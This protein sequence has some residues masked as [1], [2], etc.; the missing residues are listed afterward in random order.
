[1]NTSAV[2]V[3]VIGAG[4]Y[5]LSTYAHLRR[6]GLRARIVGEPMHAWRAHMPSG[7]FLQSG[8]SGSNLDAGE[9]GFTLAD[10]CRGAGLDPPTGDGPIPVDL[11]LRYGAW[12]ARTLAPE[13]ERTEVLAVSRS[14]S[15]YR[16]G[17]ADGAEFDARSV[18]V[19]SG[20]TGH[21]YV[22]PELA[23]LASRDEP[24]QG[25]VSH[26]SQ[27]RDLSV[28]AGREVAVV[29]AGHSALESAALLAEAGA[30]P[31]VLAR[32][33]P[34]VFARAPAPADADGRRRRRPL[35]TPDSRLGPGWPLYACSHGPAVFRRLPDGVRLDLVSRVLGPSGSWWLRD[36]VV[37]RVS[38]YTGRHL[39]HAAA[40]DDG[41]VEL[42]TVGADGLEHTVEVDHVLSATGYRIGPDAFG[43]LDPQVRRALA[44][45]H[46]WPRLRPGFES[47]VPGL[48]FVG[49][50]AAAGFG[51]LMRFVAGTSYAAPRV[52]EA[53]AARRA[54]P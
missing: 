15:G 29:G 1:M 11:F 32:R 40:R 5:G 25:P 3:L 30:L 10:Y 49:F 42:T 44:R 33:S 43:F 16:I 18:I 36:R 31:I 46:G 51:P 37:D 52:T 22:P 28:F 27:H 2:D 23:G 53:V 7:M 39:R 13:V 6:A 41:R 19:A 8:P 38:V 14:G 54:R 50:P 4:P 21:A 9:P 34:V 45:V 26:S 17:T 35:F 47:S 12:F 24:A 48:Y 20:L